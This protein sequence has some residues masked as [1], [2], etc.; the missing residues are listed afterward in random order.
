MKG[1]RN[2]RNDD[3]P[4]ERV[5]PPYTGRKKVRGRPRIL[6]AKIP[7]E[8]LNLSWFREGILAEIDAYASEKEQTT[9]VQGYHEINIQI[10]K[11]EKY[12]DWKDLDDKREF[13]ARLHA[14]KRA[15]YNGG[16]PN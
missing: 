8:L 9:T 16:N 3:R 7:P 1:K 12:K 4:L 10:G 6:S 2:E 5:K 15:S 14:R 13:M 11:Y